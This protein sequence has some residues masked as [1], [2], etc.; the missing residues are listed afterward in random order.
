MNSKAKNMF[1]EDRCI[2][3]HQKLGNKR[4][5]NQPRSVDR[6]QIASFINL[7]SLAINLKQ[8]PYFPV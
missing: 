4:K 5:A 6:C 7:A 1:A 3:Q 8:A 2:Y